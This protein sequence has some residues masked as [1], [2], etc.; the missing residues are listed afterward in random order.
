M[1]H[2]LLSPSSASRWIKCTP[3]VR[4]EALEPYTTSEAAEEGTAAHALAE[5]QLK[6]HFFQEKDEAEKAKIK[7]GKYYT[8]E[9]Q[10]HVDAYVMHC[11]ET[12]NEAKRNCDQPIVFIEHKVDLTKFAPDSFGTADFIVVADGTLYMRDLKY[13]KG[14]K[15]EAE[16][17][18]QL[19]IYGLGSIEA[20]GFLYDNILAVNVGIF[21]PRIGNIAQFTITVEALYDWAENVLRPAANKAYKGEGDFVAGKHCKFCKF[22]PKCRALRDYNMATVREDFAQPS[23]L[24]DEEILEIVRQS[25]EIKAWLK[26]VDEWVL[27]SALQGKKWPDFKLVEGRSSR[28]FVDEIQVVS[29][30]REV[31]YVD[32]DIF[33][34]AVKSITVLEKEIGKK[35]VN[36][37]LADLVVKPKG[38]PTLVAASDPRKEW[39]SAE[40]DFQAE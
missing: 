37:I 20:F 12:Y 3:S 26:T 8:E 23:N 39:S 34:K 13:G 35:R 31:G 16:E 2:A 24:S 5:I 4:K 7:A 28:K 36:E 32:E 15:V 11:I 38:S 33:N 9:M 21:Q 17:N 29:R 40:A 19:K 30:L 1:G 18:T 10:E 25:D 6:E 27:S 14:V 22:A